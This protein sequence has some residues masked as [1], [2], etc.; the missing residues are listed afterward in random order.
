MK[1]DILVAEIGSTTTLVNA[2]TG[3]NSPEPVFW[4]QGEAATSVLEGDVR[5]GLRGA[6]DD[7]CRNRGLE[8]LDYGEML[9][10]SSAAGGLK[11]TVHGLVYDMTAKAAREA[12][13][14]AGAVLKMVT[15]GLLREG[16]LDEIRAIKPN[17]IMLA[18]GV[19]H[20][21]RDTAPAN[22]K[23]LKAL[24]LRVPIIYAGNIDAQTEIKSIFEGAGIPLYIV[25]NVYPRIDELNVDPA[26]KIIQAVFEEHI[27]HA[28]G[29][30]HIRDMVTGPIIP[31]PGAVMES[32][33]LL[34]GEIG[35]LMVLDVGGATTDIH[36]VTE[37][38]EEISRMLFA[39]EPVA[40]RTVE[41]D[42][43]VYVNAM[44]LVELIGRP[45]LEAR[46]GFPLE[47]VL[48][49][50]KA[51]PKND[52]ETRFVEALTAEAVRLAFRRHAGHI[53]F[54]YGPQGRSSIA[55]GKDLTQIKYVIG[56]GGALT[57]LPGRTG[58]LQ[59]VTRADERLH[60]LSPPETAGVLVDNDYIMASLGV[61]SKRRPEA[62]LRLLRR[63]LGIS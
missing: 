9:A 4:G 48:A 41:G 12:A 37:G 24:G 26:R 33:K 38:S 56:T 10:T 11:M 5:A 27:I 23:S 35:D 53:R 17:I 19:D 34:Y 22:A 28:P 43:G 14:G 6:V 60:L 39:P 3:V 25:E 20:G 8:S 59:S 49:S 40:K 21:E 57:R 29:M 30:E 46:L 16:D 36:S 63:S 50:Y 54:V 47:G 7:L 44:N 61:L 51:I 15:S 55:E 42:L 32:A 58:I 62:A 18:G 1:I 52:A 31:T 13:L 2:F 45:E